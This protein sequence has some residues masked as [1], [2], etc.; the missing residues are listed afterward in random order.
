IIDSVAA[1]ITTE[2]G[3]G[4]VPAQLRTLLGNLIGFEKQ[5]GPYA[6]AE[7]RL[8]QA[9]KAKYAT[10]VP[11]KEAKLYSADAL[12]D[13]YAE[14]TYMP[15]TYD[16]IARAPREANRIKRDQPVFVV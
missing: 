4:A 15:R 7:L 8:H 11:E 14:Q 12:D 6:V 9:L 3:R 2:E 1:T 10:E 13:P 16:P 5:I